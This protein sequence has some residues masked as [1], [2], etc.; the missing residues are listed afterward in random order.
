MG[1]MTPE[2]ETWLP[3]PGYEGYYEA[4]D[5]GRVRSVDRVVMRSNGVSQ[6]WKGRVLRPGRAM[7]SAHLHVSLRTPCIRPKTIR[8]H[9][10]VMQTFVGPPPEGLEDCHANNDAT[11]NRLENL[12]YDTHAANMRD[13]ANRG[14]YLERVTQ[15]PN[16]HEYT[17]E[18]A[19]PV[20]G[21]GRNSRYCK[22]CKAD[23]WSEWSAAEDSDARQ[24]RNEEGRK[25]RFAM[26]AAGVLPPG[27][28]HG[29]SAYTNYG[30]RCLECKASC[31]AYAAQ[32][33]R[34][35]QS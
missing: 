30:C 33:R 35:R 31:R 34:L 9:Q 18:N 28:D 1:V 10:L 21:R 22:Q 14:I 8:V 5:M 25:K 24:R 2:I 16:G 29:Y 17:A 27:V 19:R 11:D 7:T 15:C 20:K 26:G 13:L 3:V 32:R 6:F 23:K 12:R 4:S